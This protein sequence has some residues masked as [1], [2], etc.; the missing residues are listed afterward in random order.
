LRITVIRDRGKVGN[1]NAAKANPVADHDDPPLNRKRPNV[2][3][4][5]GVLARNGQKRAVDRLDGTDEVSTDSTARQKQP[6]TRGD[7]G[8]RSR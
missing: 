4:E 8:S 6:E 3:R 2:A 7:S 1:K 5:E